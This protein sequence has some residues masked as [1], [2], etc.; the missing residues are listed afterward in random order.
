MIKTYNRQHTF[1]VLLSGGK[2]FKPELRHEL[3]HTKDFKEYETA[4]TSKS[5]RAF[6]LS[7][8]GKVVG[9]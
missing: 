2:T 8:Y 9:K 3:L 7:F 1:S 5:E 4:E 6:E